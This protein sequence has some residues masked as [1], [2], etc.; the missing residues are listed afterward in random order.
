MIADRGYAKAAEMSLPWTR[1]D[2]NGPA[3]HEAGAAS[4]SGVPLNSAPKN[5]Q[6]PVGPD[7][8]GRYRWLGGISGRSLNQA[9]HCRPRSEPG[10][11][12]GPSPRPAHLLGFIHSPVHQEIG[13]PFGD[14][15]ADPQTGTVA[16]GIIDHPVALAGEKPSSACKAVHNFLEGAMDLRSPCSP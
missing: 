11:G 5:F 13:R 16:L 10:A 15:G 6:F 9:Y 7:K 2:G 8:S 3:G 1:R 4:L 14:R 12:V